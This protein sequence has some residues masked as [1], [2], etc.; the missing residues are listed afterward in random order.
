MVGICSIAMSFYWS[1]IKLIFLLRWNDVGKIYREIENKL[2]IRTKLKHHSELLKLATL[3]LSVAH[4][5]GC[6]FRYIGILE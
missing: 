5:I 2:G 1:Y 6:C 3:I 4:V